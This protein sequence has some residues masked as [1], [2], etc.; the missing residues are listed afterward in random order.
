VN[1]TDQP[2]ELS[3]RRIGRRGTAF[4][5]AW[6]SAPAREPS[7][8]GYGASPRRAQLIK[9]QALPGLVGAL[10]GRGW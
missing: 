3:R 1:T 8:H 9:D 10:C 2:S 4:A 7:W 5:P 6:A